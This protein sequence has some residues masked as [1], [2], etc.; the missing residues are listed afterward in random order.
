MR[1]IKVWVIGLGLGAMAAA[2]TTMSREEADKPEV[3]AEERRLEERQS[4]AAQA[5]QAV[6]NF[7]KNKKEY[8]IRAENTLNSL[9]AK[10]AEL[11]VMAPADPSERE[12]HMSIVSSIEQNL[13]Q[14]R[15]NLQSLRGATPE[16]W[17]GIQRQVEQSILT[18]RASYDAAAARLS[19]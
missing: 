10:I 7:E 17:D 8:I 3:S 11:K 6:T 15:S 4:A 18:T 14:A 16:S 12:S 19:H 9:E 5:G 13:T 2:C 1:Q